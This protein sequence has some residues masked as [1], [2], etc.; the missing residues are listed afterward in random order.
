MNYLLFFL[1]VT[2]TI[3]QDEY[4]CEDDCECS[5]ILDFFWMDRE[6]ILYT[7]EAGCVRNITCVNTGQTF[8]QFFYNESEIARPVDSNKDYGHAMSLNPEALTSD[9][10]IFEFF[11][12]VCENKEWY[13]TK[14][15]RGILYQ[16][17]T[18]EEIVI[19]ANGVFDG[20]KSK[21]HD[22]WWLI[23]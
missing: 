16:I 7:E 15:P 19:G 9:I 17:A 1:L 23:V 10:N 13:I 20:K 8:V 14:Y 11:G 4:G 12:M 6:S 22:Y 5:D 3:C 2:V 21:I 18:G